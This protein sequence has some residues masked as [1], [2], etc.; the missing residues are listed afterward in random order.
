MLAA[1][2]FKNREE[3]KRKK[4]E[5]LDRFLKTHFSN[6]SIVNHFSQVGTLK[7]VNYKGCK[8]DEQYIKE[9]FEN[10]FTEDD[11]KYFQLKL[12]SDDESC[13]IGIG[14]SFRP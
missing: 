1:Q 7:Y 2:I 4:N 11:R 12:D 6:E 14:I 9:W 5:Q 10:F 13:N 8:D 3:L